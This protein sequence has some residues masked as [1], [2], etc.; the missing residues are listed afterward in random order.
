LMP[1][2][3]PREIVNTLSSAMKKV[4]A[5]EEHK[6]KMAEMGLSLRY[7]D[8]AQLGKFWDDSETMVKELEPHLK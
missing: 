4:M 1:A 2:G 6:K 8:P 5:T 3:T 7:M